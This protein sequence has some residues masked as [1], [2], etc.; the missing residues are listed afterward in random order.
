MLKTMKSKVI[1]GAVA[2]GVL[3]GGGAVLGATDAGVALKGWYDAKFGSASEKIAVDSAAYA[4]SLAPGLAA[5]YQVEKDR[6]TSKLKGE[7]ETSIS[8]AN[9][10]I[11]KKSKE[12]I[13]Q[14]NAQKSH[15]ESYMS[16][17]FNGLSSLA[18]G[19]IEKSGKEALAYANGDLANHAGSEGQKAVGEVNVKVKE[20]TAEAASKL[21]A[22][23]DESKKSLQSQLD[24]QQA[25]TTEEIKHMIDSEISK[26]R[27]A[28]INT[29]NKLIFDNEKKIK[30]A[31]HALRLAAESQL[32]AIVGN[33]NK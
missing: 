20:A 3:S 5:D 6:A 1:A 33:I 23:I 18:K 16:S 21:Q 29:N 32:D 12:Y 15:I 28:I 10:G 25:K 8:N 2:V 4:T 30:S 7:G 11:D 24:S 26:L 27:G 13:D 19:L 22:A 17:Q 31:A 14:I 9:G